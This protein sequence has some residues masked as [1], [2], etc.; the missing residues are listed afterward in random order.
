MRRGH[1]TLQKENENSD[2]ASK[3]QLSPRLIP[4]AGDRA[5]CAIC[6]KS[7]EQNLH[8]GATDRHRYEIK[9]APKI[10]IATNALTEEKSLPRT[11]DKRIRGTKQ[12]LP[13]PLNQSIR[14]P[15]ASQ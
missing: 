7:Q 10:R 14:L 5:P 3:K 13:K 11:R 12:K 2:F 4:N 1:G 15:P 6:R 8:T 9:K